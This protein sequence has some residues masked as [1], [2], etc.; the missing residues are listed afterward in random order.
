MK[1]RVMLAAAAGAVTIFVLGY[2]IYGVLLASYLKEHMIQY[3]GLNKEPMPDFVPLFLSN[4]VVAFLLAFI[5][6]KWAGIRTVSTGLK[7]GAVVMFLII[8]SK[9]LSFMGYMNLFKGV[10]PVIVDVLAET[11]RGSLAG[12]VIGGILG[13]HSTSEVS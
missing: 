3:A 6:D 2:L 8:L 12:G 1:T 5:F 4:L 10:M 7:G 9:D 13:F 11:T